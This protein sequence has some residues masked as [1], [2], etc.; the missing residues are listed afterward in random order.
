MKISVVG[1]GAAGIVMVLKLLETKKDSEITWYGGE[2]VMK[3]ERRGLYKDT[4]FGIAYGKC[5]PEH[6]LNVP[7]EKMS[8]YEGDRS[9]IEYINRNFPRK[10]S[11]VGSL[12]PRFWYKK[13]LKWL[14]SL[15]P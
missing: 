2:S 14:L 6:M 12:V 1:N 3:I 5:G 13:Y 4:P 15:Y 8:V 9:F 7:A 11:Y 10:N